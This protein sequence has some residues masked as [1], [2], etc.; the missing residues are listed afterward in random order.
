GTDDKSK[1]V[2]E[3]A[4]SNGTVKLLLADRVYTMNL[5]GEVGINGW[6]G[7]FTGSAKYGPPNFDYIEWNFEFKR[8]TGETV[9]WKETCW[10]FASGPSSLVSPTPTLSPTMDGNQ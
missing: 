10:P 3:G 5:S 7:S 8:E 1:A 2:A 9:R 6:T 4:Q